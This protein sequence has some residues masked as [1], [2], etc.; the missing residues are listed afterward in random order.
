MNDHRRK[1]EKAAKEEALQAKIEAAAIGIKSQA[2]GWKEMLHHTHAKRRRVARRGR[3]KVGANL[4]LAGWARRRRR[5]TLLA[6]EGTWHKYLD[7]VGNSNFKARADAVFY[8]D[9]HPHSEMPYQWDPP[10]HWE[11]NAVAIAEVSCI[12][13]LTSM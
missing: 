10:E 11:I 7:T 3:G 4:G 2:L 13:H 12:S 5:S 6:T 9:S 1:R 8:Y